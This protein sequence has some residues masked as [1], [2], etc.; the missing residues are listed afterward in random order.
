MAWETCTMC[1]GYG[2][3]EEDDE[4]IDCPQC[5]GSGRIDSAYEICPRT[6]R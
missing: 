4:E 5:D 2:F 6:R 1:D 3:I